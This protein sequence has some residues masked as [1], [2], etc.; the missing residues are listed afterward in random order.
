M[1]RQREAGG[2]RQ[3]KQ[4]RRPQQNRAIGQPRKEQ[5]R[6]HEREAE[7]HHDKGRAEPRSR[8]RR[9]VA[10]EQATEGELQRVLGS[11]DE[12]GDPDVERHQRADPRHGVE[13]L[14]RADGQRPA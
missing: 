11:K 7:R 4:E 1:A 14:L 2:K 6:G 9:K 10:V 12:S 3:A 13:A 5:E 8:N